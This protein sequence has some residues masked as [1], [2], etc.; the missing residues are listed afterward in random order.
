M[1]FVSA[2]LV[3]PTTDTIPRLP[4]SA[5]RTSHIDMLFDDRTPGTLGLRGR[6]RDLTT[7]WRERA[8]VVAEA[9]VDAHLDESRRLVS[10]VTEPLEPAVQGLLGLE[11]GRGFRAALHDTA[12]QT[13][14]DGDPLHLLLDDLPV[15]AL[16]SGYAKLYDSGG[17]PNSRAQ[18]GDPGGAADGTADGT[19][20]GTAAGTA[21]PAARLV[22]ED[23]CSGWRRDGTMM[24]SL[25]SGH[26]FPAPVGPPAPDLS[27]TDPV[28]WHHIDELPPNS[29]RRR[30]LIDVVAGDPLTVHAMFRDTHTGPDG[31][32]RVLHE[33]TVEAT[34]QA[35]TLRILTCHATPRSLPWAECPE[36]A[37]SAT[38]LEGRL[39]GELRSFVLREL[40]GTS[41]C[42]HLND[43]LRSLAEIAPLAVIVPGPPPG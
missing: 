43:L 34:V 20:A 22:K 13:S 17:S 5:R 16:I 14:A 1:S 6:A 29:M 27:T 36:A 8:E 39:A 3:Q 42:T 21:E 4:A 24:V 38:R 28:G 37:L 40:R 7:D 11:V 31:V 25:R 12:W 26:G 33:Y 32:E 19:A 2:S 10:L 18:G 30:R 23:I 41:T 15:A 35:S 9:R